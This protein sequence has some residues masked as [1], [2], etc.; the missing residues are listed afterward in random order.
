MF[1][2][3]ENFKIKMVEGDFGIVLPIKILN[4]QLGA[5]DKFSI[6][7]FK[8]INKEPIVTKEF[9]NIIDN[10]IEFS[11]SKEESE[12]LP[13]GRYYYDLDWFQDNA[14][15]GNILAKKQFQVEEKAGM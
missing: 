12:K 9:S 8:E 4:E 10:V 2:E 15:L 3:E 13:V 11:L 1:K 6:K 7:I 5:N 14:F